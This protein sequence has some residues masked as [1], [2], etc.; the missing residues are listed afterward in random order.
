MKYLKFLKQALAAARNKIELMA[1]NEYTIAAYFRKRGAQIGKNCRILVHSF[2]TEPYLVKIG[3]N[4]T[5]APHVA[6]MTHD[7][8]VGMFRGEY[9]DINV[10]G[11]IDI[12]DN[13]FIGFGSIIMYNVTIGPNAIV[14]AGSVVTRDVPP[15]TIVAGVP[16][17]VLGT[18]DDYKRKCLAQWEKI[19]LQGD[20]STWQKQL[21]DYFW[22]ERKGKQ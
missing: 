3:D 6:L 22:P 20:R 5:I 2:G 14:G 16:A 17:R 18:V 19:G 9:P 11:K 13:C 4:C 15:N 7:G 12:R 21:V 10:F 8:S 1:H